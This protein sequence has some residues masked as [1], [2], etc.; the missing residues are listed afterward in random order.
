MRVFALS[1]IHI[2]YNENSSW[3][4]NLSEYDYKDDILILAGDVTDIIPSL[5]K[6][7]KA[8]KNRFGNVLYT[9]G[10]HDLWV[11]R[12]N[13][14]NSLESFDIIKKISKDCGISMEPTEF[15]SLS[16]IPLFGWF[17]YSFGQPSNKLFDIWLDYIA[18]KWPDD[19]DETK[20]TR[21][22]ISINEEFL[23][24]T[25]KF[26]ISFSHFLPRID[27]MPFYIPPYKKIL[28]PVLGTSLLEGQIRTLGSQIHI[29][30]H[31]HVN[32]RVLK[33]NTIYINNAFGYPSET[34]I[35]AKE[36]VCVFEL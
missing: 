26:V 25:N 23:N 1:D 13:V 8:L 9:P 33:D 18:C 21:Y 4:Y 24:T 31:S 19:F 34:L 35:T 17:D 29:Y 6:A 30:G 27:L 11:N 32:M 3:L 28:Y 14:K 2:D 15:G 22:F 20:I 12:N 16:I 36:L 10:N 5:T 7:F